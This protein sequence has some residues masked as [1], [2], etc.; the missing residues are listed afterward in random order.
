M[1]AGMIA[2]LS[3]GIGVL[4]MLLNLS[5]SAFASFKG[6]RLDA[7][8]AETCIVLGRDISSLL[9]TLFMCYWLMFLT[10]PVMVGGLVWAAIRAV[11]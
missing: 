1:S 2:L 9:Y 7:G 4:P 11:Q 6:V 5:A 10:L 8:E 3:V